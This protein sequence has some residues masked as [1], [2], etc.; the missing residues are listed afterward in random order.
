[1]SGINFMNSPCDCDGN[2]DEL[3]C[4]GCD[5]VVQENAAA[6]AATAP[7]TSD[8][9]RL[10]VQIKTPP[11]RWTDTDKVLPYPSAPSRPDSP[12]SPNAPTWS[13]PRKVVLDVTKEI[14]EKVRC[15]CH[16]LS[17]PALACPDGSLLLL[18]RSSKHVTRTSPPTSP[19]LTS[20]DSTMLLAVGHVQSCGLPAGLLWSRADQLAGDHTQCKWL[21]SSPLSPITR[22]SPWA[23]Q[24]YQRS[25]TTFPCDFQNT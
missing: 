22:Q 9:G 24:L 19:A 16:H 10:L 2:S 23:Q 21:G 1:M 12:T 11:R 4:R 20:L 18:C 7:V 6:L 8:A 14:L 15:R 5:E 3:G 13:P 25:G 17:Q